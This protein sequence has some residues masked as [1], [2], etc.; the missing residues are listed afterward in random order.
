MTVLQLVSWKEDEGRIRRE[1]LERL[2]HQVVFHL[3]DPGGLLRVLKEDPPSVVIIDLSR[4]PANGRDLGVALRVQATT[5]G[6]PLVSGGHPDKVGEDPG[7]PPRRRVCRMGSG[8]RCPEK[9]TDRPPDRTQS[10][11]TPCWRATRERPFQQS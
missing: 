2:G 9:G 3:L 1:E 8:R 6:I 11:P 4:S 10:C 5:R 7:S